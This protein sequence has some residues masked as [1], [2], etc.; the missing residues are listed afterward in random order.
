MASKRIGIVLDPLDTLNIKKDS[1]LAI[2]Q[3]L[4]KRGHHLVVFRTQDLYA[5][6]GAAFGRGKQI[7]LALDSTPFYKVVNAGECALS[8]LDLILMRKDPPFDAEFIHATHILEL[9]KTRVINHPHALRLLN[10]KASLH[11]FPE[12]IPPTLMTKRIEQLNTFLQ[13]HKKIVVKPLN[14]MGGASIFLVD[15]DDA[16][17][18]VIFETITHGQTQTMIAQ[19][20]LPEIKQGDQR[21]L[22]FFGQ[23]VSHQL[24]RIPSK[25]D[26]RGNLA[27]GASAQVAPLRD[28][29]IKICQQLAPFFAEHKIDLVGLDMIGD[30]ITEINITS[31][32]G[33]REISQ[34]AG[35]D[36]AAQ[37]VD[38]LNL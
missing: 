28:S 21:I 23:P 25:D 2:M 24:V 15:E 38:G 30:K 22:I 27:A 37:F 20:Y 7:E 16:N 26:H 4:Q 31:P 10:E 19:K 8:D 6:T 13:A 34:L 5:L 18:Q 29:Q 9:A 17:R 35:I 1:S 32:T 36:V 3:E 12:L 33:F 14:Q 11:L